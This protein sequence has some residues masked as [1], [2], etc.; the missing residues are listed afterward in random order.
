MTIEIK[1]HWSN[2]KTSIIDW[3]KCSQPTK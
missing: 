2:N 1:N 3:H